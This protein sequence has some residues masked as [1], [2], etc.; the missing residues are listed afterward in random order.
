MCTCEVIECTEY[1]PFTHIAY[2]YVYVYIY[3]Y[4]YVY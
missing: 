1:T 4:V 2:V 3:E